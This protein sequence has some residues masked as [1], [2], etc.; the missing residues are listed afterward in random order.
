M[1]SRSGVWK[2]MEIVTIPDILDRRRI[3]TGI[4]RY[5]ISQQDTHSWCSLF[6]VQVFEQLSR[7]LGGAK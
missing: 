4:S 6:S 2:I 3:N 5:I 7:Q 1:C